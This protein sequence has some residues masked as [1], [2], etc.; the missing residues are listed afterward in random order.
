LSLSDKAVIFPAALRAPSRYCINDPLRFSLK[1]LTRRGG[2]HPCGHAEISEM[3]AP[4][5]L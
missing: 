1:F 2:F 3:S 5:A 4:H